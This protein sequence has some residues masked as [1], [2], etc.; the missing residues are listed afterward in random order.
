MAKKSPPKLKAELYYSNT[1]CEKLG[2][3]AAEGSPAA[4]RRIAQQHAAIL[5]L[6]LP[7]ETS[8]S[9]SVEQVALPACLFSSDALPYSYRVQLTENCTHIASASRECA[10]TPPQEIRLSYSGVAPILDKNATNDAVT[11]PLTNN[12]LYS[13]VLEPAMTKRYTWNGATCTLRE[14]LLAVAAMSDA[15]LIELAEDGPASKRHHF[16]LLNKGFLLWGLPRSHEGRAPD[17]D[18]ISVRCFTAKTL[19]NLLAVLSKR[20]GASALEQLKTYAGPAGHYA[21]SGEF[22]VD[23]VL[24]R[25]K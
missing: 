8:S 2:A 24:H 21:P 13:S 23:F 6:A 19:G 5:G 20:H 25:I 15:K 10:H 3:L 22:V 1:V 4:Y 17:A 11:N 14:R 12:W 7:P 18:R 9:L 16:W